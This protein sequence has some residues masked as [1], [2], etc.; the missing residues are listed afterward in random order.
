MDAAEEAA[1][2]AKSGGAA[3]KRSSSGRK[4]EAAGLRGGRNYSSLPTVTSI[5]SSKYFTIA[6]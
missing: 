1:G 2:G 5:L 3:L 4:S 6:A